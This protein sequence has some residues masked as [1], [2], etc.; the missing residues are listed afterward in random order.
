LKGYGGYWE[1]VRVDWCEFV[2][3]SHFIWARRINEVPRTK[4]E[5]P[6]GEIKFYIELRRRD[7]ESTCTLNDTGNSQ[8]PTQAAESP[9]V[10]KLR[11]ESL[12]AVFIRLSVTICRAIR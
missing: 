10:S 11:L 3:C 5:T 7:D 12:L 1:Y 2:D 9:T 8:K 4:H 6:N